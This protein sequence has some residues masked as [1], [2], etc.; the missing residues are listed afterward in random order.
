MKYRFTKSIN[1]TKSCIGCIFYDTND[2]MGDCPRNNL[3]GRKLCVVSGTKSWDE[4]IYSIITG[5]GP[6]LNKNIKVI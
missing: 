5:I 4:Y 6:E 3:V 1:N 2:G